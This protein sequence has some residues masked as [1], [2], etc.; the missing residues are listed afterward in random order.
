MG[1]YVEHINKVLKPASRQPFKALD[2]FAGCG[3]LSLGFEA[4]GFRT[5]GFEMLKSAADTYNANLKGV[6]YAEK[7]NVGFKYPSEKYDLIIGGPPCQPF[8]VGGYQYGADDARNGFPIFIDAVKRMKPQM[9]MFENVRGMLYS[10]KQ[11][12]DSV[13]N[14]LTA[15]GWEI[16][17]LLINA[18]DYGVPQNRQ[19]LFVVGYRSSFS[20]PPKIARKFTVGEAIG[21][22][23]EIT[24]QIFNPFNG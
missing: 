17:P 7:L 15:S 20:F 11:Y 14:E 18:V 6:C 24:I 12:L 10:N 4:A 13:L 8:S 3:G 19:R 21:D 5:T 1:D 9:W 2:L 16:A 23:I 22:L